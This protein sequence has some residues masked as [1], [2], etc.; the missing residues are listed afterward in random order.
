MFSDFLNLIFAGCTSDFERLAA[1]MLFVFLLELLA[2]LIA[3]LTGGAR[4]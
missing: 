4:R 3:S 1:F 2:S